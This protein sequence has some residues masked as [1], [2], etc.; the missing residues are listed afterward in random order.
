LTRSIPVALGGR[1][2]DVI[3]GPGLIDRAGEHIAP[4]LKSKRT[5]SSP[6]PSSANITGSGCRSRWSAPASPST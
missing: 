5:P 2:Y 3:V 1:S 6:T 4:L